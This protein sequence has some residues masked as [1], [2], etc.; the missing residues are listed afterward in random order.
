MRAEAMLK[1]EDT[2]T[3][4]P[5]LVGAFLPRLLS[6]VSD[7]MSAASCPIRRKQADENETVKERPNVN[8]RTTID[9]FHIVKPLSKGA[10]GK[11]YLARKIAT[12]DLFAIKVLRKHDML[13][14]NMAEQVR[15]ILCPPPPPQCARRLHI[16]PTPP[17]VSLQPSVKQ[18]RRCVR[19][20]QKE[21]QSG[22]SQALGTTFQHRVR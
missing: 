15:A 14:K 13:V 20:A 7:A 11:V 16:D 1:Q 12:G 21:N 17:R 3:K 6:V 18:K 8:S 10:Y 2:G 22:P 9:D 4:L 19:R 5:L